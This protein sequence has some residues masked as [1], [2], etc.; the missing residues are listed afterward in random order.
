MAKKTVAGFRKD[1]DTQK[2]VKLVK[3]VKNK[4][5]NYSFKEMIIKKENVD[6]NL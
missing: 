6:K 3:T 2:F 5:G 4:K 1:T